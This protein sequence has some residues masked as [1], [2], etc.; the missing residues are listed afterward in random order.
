MARDSS[1]SHG[2]ASIRRWDTSDFYFLFLSMSIK[3]KEQ[4]LLLESLQQTLAC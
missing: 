1:Y 2:A 3:D 4:K